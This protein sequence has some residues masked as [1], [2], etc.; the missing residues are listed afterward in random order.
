M[1]SG[2]ATLLQWRRIFHS[3]DAE[4]TRAYLPETYG[5]NLRFEPAP[6]QGRRADVR[7]DGVDL[8]SR[9]IHH[10]RWGAKVVVEGSSPDPYYV[11]LLPIIGCIEASAAG[12]S[13]E[14]DPR[15]AVIFSRPTMPAPTLSMNAS[16][17]GL[18]LTV[19]QTAVARQLTAL[20]GEPAHASVEFA[21]TMDLTKGHG[22]SL[23]RYLL[24]AATDFKRTGAISWN[25]ITIS[26]FE[27]LIISR[28]LSHPHNYSKALRKAEK[29]IAP[30][31]V[32]RAIEYM[33]AKLGSPITIADIAEVSG[34]AG[35]TLFK[36][37]RDFQG[38]TPMGYLRNARFQKVRETLIRA[39]P[40]EGVTVIA[41]SWGFSHMGRF[42][43]EYRKR[44]GE[45][46]SETLGRRHRR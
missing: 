2:N 28:L 13:V 30:R 35:R 43:V 36:H 15:R 23:A 40:E 19:S 38:L 41:M 5:K 20:L 32:K 45:S 46:P 25:P 3:Q 17:A 12:F 6:R 31:D 42:S 7:I 33:D 34:I 44:Y 16:T 39:Q 9:F 8:P 29:P 18:N 10:G 24:L 11:I 37:F 1:G 14:C 26:A 27:E 4:E 22:Q 21:P